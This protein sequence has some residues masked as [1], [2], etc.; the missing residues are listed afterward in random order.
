MSIRT[1]EVDFHLKADADHTFGLLDEI[2]PPGP[3]EVGQRLKATDGEVTRWAG[4]LTA[5]T[6]R[7]PL[8]CVLWTEGCGGQS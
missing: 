7:V 6:N 8:C 4:S 2:R 3:V 1:I 5:P